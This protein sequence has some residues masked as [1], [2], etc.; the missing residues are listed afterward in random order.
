MHWD[1]MEWDQFDT[2]ASTYILWRDDQGEAR[3][4]A[5]LIPTSLPYMVQQLWPDLAASANLPTGD[6]VWEV[7]RLGVDPQ[8][9]KERRPRVFRE[10][11]CSLIEFALSRQIHQY[12]FAT[13]LSIINYAIGKAGVEWTRLGSGT[14]GGLQAIA[15]RVAVNVETLHRM[16]QYHQVEETLLRSPTCRSCTPITTTNQLK[17]SRN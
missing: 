14:L 13:R 1:G 2:P 7:S 9:D 16:R 6:D 3:G 4:I 8:L 12:I 5:R 10:L 11:L 17:P 15:A